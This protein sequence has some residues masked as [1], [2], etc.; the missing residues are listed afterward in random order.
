MEQLSLVID[1]ILERIEI[2]DDWA[3]NNGLVVCIASE[4]K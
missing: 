3:D 2:L 4:V 1:E